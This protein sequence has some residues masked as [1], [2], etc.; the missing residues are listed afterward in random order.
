MTVKVM[1]VWALAAKTVVRLQVMVSA[2]TVQVKLLMLN[3][4][5]PL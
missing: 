3:G 5:V 4:L 2:A 1:V